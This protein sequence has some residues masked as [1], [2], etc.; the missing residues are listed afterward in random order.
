MKKIPMQKIITSVL[1]LLF[2]LLLFAADDN[3]L[4]L[5][6]P[7]S[8]VSVIFLS[9]IFGVVDGV[10]RGTGSQIMGAMFSV[11]NS[12]VLA[13]GGIII[14]YTL[15]VSTVNTAHEGQM[16]GQKWSS[17]WV[18]VRS[19][20]GLTLLIPKASGY[21]LMQIM[22]MWIVVQGVG[23]GDKVW[24]AALSYLN[25]GGVMVQ[26]QIDPIKMIMGTG[27]PILYGASQILY[28]QICM[29]GIETILKE[30]RKDLLNSDEK[31]SPCESAPKNSAVDQLCK[32]PVPDFIGS[33][34]FNV[35]HDGGITNKNINNTI[36]APMPFFLDKTGTQQ[37]NIYG[38]MN[39]ICGHI[40]WSSFKNSDFA[41]Y[42]GKLTSDD[43]NVTLKARTTAVQQM[44]L[45]LADVARIMVDNDPALLY[46]TPLPTGSTP[47]TPNA[48]DQFGI[49]TNINGG[50]CAAAP[51]GNTQ[52]CVSWGSAGGTTSPLFA[53]TEL[54][55]AVSDY[56]AVLLPTLTLMAT[57]DMDISKD[58][59]R[60]F[61][62]GAS[63]TGWMMAGSY[64]YQLSTLS[65]ANTTSY[66]NNPNYQGSEGA[67]LI[68]E[69]SGLASSTFDLD[70]VNSGF[71]SAT[72][73]GT[74]AVSIICEAFKNPITGI[75]TKEPLKS[76]LNLIKPETE[77]KPGFFTIPTDNK[78]G[79]GAV[80]TP[81]LDLQTSSTGYG[82]V[83]NALMI[84]I[85]KQAGNEAPKFTMD[86]TTNF[87][88]KGFSLPVVSIE[89]QGFMC[90]PSVMGEI[91]YNYVVRLFIQV[92]ITAVFT[93]L[94][95][96][97][98]A[99]LALPLLGI[100]EIFKTS[101]AFIQNP[102]ANPIVALANMGINYINFASD[103]W[104]YLLVLGVAQ[105]F[106]PYAG[107][108]II[109]MMLMALPLLMAWLGVMLAIGYLTAY[110]IP[111]VPYMIF[112]F[113]S[114]A[115]LM[116]VIEAMVAAPIVALSITHPEGE[117]PFGG[118]A[119]QSFMILMNVFLR[120]SLM[121]IGYIAGIIL[122]YVSVWVINTGFMNVLPFMQ[123][124]N[125]W[126]GNLTKT[127]D[128]LPVGAATKKDA[129]KGTP[130][131]DKEGK[132]IGG[133]AISIDRKPV[134]KPAETVKANYIGWAGIYGFF[135][136]I[137]IYTSMYLTVVQKAFSLIGIL[138]DKVLRWI[139]GQPESIG[140][141][142][143]GWAEES[144][145]QVEGA[146]KATEK[147]AGQIGKEAGS[148]GLE[149]A[150]KVKDLTSKSDVGASTPGG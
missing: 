72:A 47:A 28:G 102:D 123:G 66:S 3:S 131:F 50:P 64:F 99:F 86:I 135:F 61:I 30:R 142:A 14:M 111:F 13:L 20:L 9:N 146:G 58:D 70:F 105:I 116:A 117:G 128:W 90:I 97:L 147:A 56:N 77:P 83:N 24:Q 52:D 96:V 115:W 31:P 53:G 36:V 17:I 98:M 107:L 57:K 54:K 7:S 132:A 48:R 26:Q 43:M 74:S 8:D 33:L 103:M 78:S 109:P 29:A 16:L 21:C 150:K 143:A 149:G 104:M 5:K 121:I 67:G 137:I 110:Y 89:C 136:A 93:V 95:T 106:I 79:T 140:Q 119:E 112:T 11:F 6:P 49:P 19:T 87:S 23:A 32:N 124:P 22:F 60:D 62:K 127:E 44:Y 130:L 18:P 46:K 69:N 76:V 122:S 126:Q 148:K 40:R 88:V 118:K 108:F 84:M 63:Q 42:K 92:V 10:L 94:N 4:S 113:A 125:S 41:Q 81:V 34:D 82:Y 138:P 139:G 129:E 80:I 133:Y 15:I 68:D 59:P 12:A 45:D 38:S 120:P 65:A 75:S 145:K 39:G 27:S 114:I 35:I 71:S 73:C 37:D 100:A 134:A 85:A 144:K 51:F 55:G 101:V 2:P 91:L 25:R 1:F 141:E